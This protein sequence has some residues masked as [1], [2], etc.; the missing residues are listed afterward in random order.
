[1]GRVAEDTNRRRFQLP[2]IK[3]DAGSNQDSD[4]WIPAHVQDHRRPL[5]GPDRTE[6]GFGGK[7]GETDSGRLVE[8][9]PESTADGAK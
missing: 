3:Q 9:P 7:D 4:I 5:F 1:M 2:I 6:E 8:Q